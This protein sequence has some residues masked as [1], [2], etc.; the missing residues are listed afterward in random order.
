[1]EGLA[2]VAARL[3]AILEAVFFV[4]REPVSLEKLASALP[5]TTPAEI[6]GSIA[7]ISRRYRRQNRPYRIALR[8]G[9]YVLELIPAVAETLWQ[10]SRSERGV[11]L[12]RAAVEVLSV[13]A[14]RQP[15]ARQDVAELLAV[16]VRPA[17]R[18]LVRHR[19]IELE[20][21][22]AG[23]PSDRYVTTARF[24]ELFGLTDL[25]DLPAA[26]GLERL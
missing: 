5:E 14:Y 9:G 17:L 13:V 25:G 24:L 3:G 21:A 23:Q 12:N 6:T 19:L 4:G 8:G 15:I 18:Q 26:G 7:A 11:R 16:D 1:L 20:S 2:N 22:G 10:R